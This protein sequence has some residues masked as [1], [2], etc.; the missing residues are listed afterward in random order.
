MDSLHISLVDSAAKQS[1]RKFK[2]NIDHTD[3]VLLFYINFKGRPLG[4]DMGDIDLKL[5]KILTEFGWFY[6]H[7]G[8]KL[9]RS[10]TRWSKSKSQKVSR[11]FLKVGA[12]GNGVS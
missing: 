11:N 7:W 2:H 9:I 4:L 1:A 10:G 5:Q 8:L 3:V 12:M 6:V